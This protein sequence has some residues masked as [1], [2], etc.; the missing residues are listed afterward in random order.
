MCLCC[1]C[2]GMQYPVDRKEPE[3][4]LILCRVVL[5]SVEKVG[6]EFHQTCPSRQEYDTGSDDPANPRWYVVWASDMNTRIVPVCVVTCNTFAI[7]PGN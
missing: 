7:L 5:G 1:F 4:H 3:K 2:S 6:L